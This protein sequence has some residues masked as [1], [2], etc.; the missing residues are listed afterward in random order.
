MSKRTQIG[1]VVALLGV[2]ASLGAV[3][4]EVRQNT[5]AVAGQTM[6]ALAQEHAG[7]SRL[8]VEHPDLRVAWELS[9]RDIALLTPEQSDLL[10]WYYTAVMRVTEN[11]YRQYQLGTLSEDALTQFGLQGNVFRN[12]YFKALWPDWKFQFSED[13]AAWVE[14]TL[15]PLETRPRPLV[16]G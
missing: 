14:Q 5:K 9:F 11:R 16:G 1:Q 15:L 2:I 3:A 12:P 13:F 6:Q 7:L 8:G 4:Y 10:A